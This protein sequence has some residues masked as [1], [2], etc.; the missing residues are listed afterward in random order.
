[1]RLLELADL[2]RQSQYSRQ[3]ADV[4]VKEIIFEY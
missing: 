3:K 4:E 1:M 2:S